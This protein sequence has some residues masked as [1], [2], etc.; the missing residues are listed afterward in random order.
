MNATFA[1]LIHKST[2]FRCYEC[3]LGIRKMLRFVPSYA[4]VI[5]Y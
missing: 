3:F 4:L 1:L 5:G 2:I